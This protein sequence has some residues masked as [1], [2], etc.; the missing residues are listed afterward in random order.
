MKTL[1]L[2]VAVAISGCALDPQ[3]DQPDQPAAR[4]AEA[5]GIVANPPGDEP[6]FDN[7]TAVVNYCTWSSGSI[8]C[9]D[10]YTRLWCTN[11][12]DEVA[13]DHTNCQWSGW[14]AAGTEWCTTNQPGY[15]SGYSWGQSHT[16]CN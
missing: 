14:N 1:T 7:N 8:W 13:W 9:Q 12:K 2:L 6:V 4:E 11:G 5:T 15:A 10:Y 16:H 3:P